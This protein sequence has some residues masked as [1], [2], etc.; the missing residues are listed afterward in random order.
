[1]FSLHR[2][3]LPNIL[4]FLF[5]NSDRAVSRSLAKTVGQVLG[6]PAESKVSAGE[7]KGQQRHPCP[8]IPFFLAQQMEKSHSWVAGAGRGRETLSLVK[9]LHEGRRGEALEEGAL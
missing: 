4:Q 5:Q 9:R 8:N 1:M 2:P 6:K 3:Q 7:R